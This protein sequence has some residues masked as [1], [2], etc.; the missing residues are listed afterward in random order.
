VG[1]QNSF[2]VRPDHVETKL[3]WEVS[4]CSFHKSG[5]PDDK[6]TLR[7]TGKQCNCSSTSVVVEDSS[8][9]Q[10]NFHPSCSSEGLSIVMCFRINRT[11]Y[12]ASVK[13]STL[14]EDGHIVTA[15]YL[16]QNL[17]LVVVIQISVVDLLQ[18]KHL[19]EF[20][21]FPMSSLSSD[22]HRPIHIYMKNLYPV[23]LVFKFSHV[24]FVKSCLFNALVNFVTIYWKM[25]RVEKSKITTVMKVMP[26]MGQENLRSWSCSYENVLN[27]IFNKW[28]CLCCNIAL[29]CKGWDLPFVVFVAAVMLHTTHPEVYW[30]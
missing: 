22:I 13:L 18:N 19:L 29:K 16:Q 9:F 24:C 23:I 25:M 26:P 17:V 11:T 14:T 1:R 10:L 4:R 7:A 30:I 5:Q 2:S 6:F 15:L 27:I 21:L 3:H 8:M 20:A 28:G 12:C